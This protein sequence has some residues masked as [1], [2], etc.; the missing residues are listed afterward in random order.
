MRTF[1]CLLALALGLSPAVRADEP[2]PGA[3]HWD[4]RQDWT[5]AG[6]FSIEADTDGY[7]LP[8]AIAFV[9]E[10]GPDPG[11]PLYF[12]TELRGTVKVVTR[13]RRVHT[14]ADGFLTTEFHDAS[15]DGAAE[16]GLAGLCLDP[17]HGYVYV[18]F[19]YQDGRK[20]LRNDIIRFTTRPGRF[21]LA[22]TAQVTFRD[23][24]A[25]FESGV[26]HQIGPCQVAGDAL[27]VSVGD[28]FSTPQDSQR[29]EM[30]LGKVLRL[31]LDGRPLP[32]NPY[33]RADAPDAPAGAV[34]A[35]GLRNPFSLRLVDGRL[36]AADN[37]LNTDR[38]VEI[39]R[40]RNYL[41]DGS[42]RSMGINAAAVIAP[43]VGPVQMDFLPRA[44]PLV[45]EPE[46]GRFYAAL[47]GKVAGIMTF[48]F[49]FAS[50]RMARGPAYFMQ[51]VSGRRQMLTGLAFGP[52]GLYFCPIL[53]DATG[54][55][56][57]FRIEHDAAL[58]HSSTLMENPVPWVLMYERGCFG[59]HRMAGELRGRDVGPPLDR[60]PLIERL[61]AQLNAP[62]YLRSLDEVD[63][64]DTEPQR[65]YRDIRR[66]LREATGLERV[67]L[68]TQYRIHDPLFDRLETRMPNSGL[69]LREAE[70]IMHYL[71]GPPPRPVAWRDR[72]R[73]V[74]ESRVTRLI[75]LGGGCFVAGVG[76]ALVLPGLRRR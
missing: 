45:P 8:T 38:F 59:C 55:S 70:R 56:A 60:E 74:V 41:W 73:G 29:L 52:D 47:S 39:D 13:D 17:E 51:S 43:S 9:P 49:D 57:V 25:P 20:V 27:Y 10:P 31:T 67:R 65:R 54:R 71:I 24:F 30:L 36:F 26:S 14:F 50:S 63:A 68:W 44:S 42:E 34:W 23:L 62:E 15:P 19:A 76:A 2:S 1:T 33:Y 5:L 46:R 7:H 6:G 3:A 64:V 58:E 48:E 21:G 75:L 4:W 16:F 32:D 37:G 66:R 40:G 53:P 12:V 18:T 35:Y 28:G 22:P 72:L 61:T 11:D 69:S